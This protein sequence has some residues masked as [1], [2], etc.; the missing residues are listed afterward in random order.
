[1]RGILVCALVL[2]ASAADA[3]VFAHVRSGQPAIRGWLAEGYE[4]SATFKA[5][6]DE[7]DTLP[8]IVYIETGTVMRPGLDGALLHTVAGSRESPLLRVV[9][10]WSLTR[11]TGIATIAHE[12]QHVV[13]VLRA[14][15][16]TDSSAMTA[17]FESIGKTQPRGASQFE[18]EAAR[19]VT[20]RVLDELAQRSKR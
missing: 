16:V 19:E 12:L 6:V 2:V 1:M 8:G 9:V 4:R 10:R 11:A 18:T 7:I 3:E 13:E 5:L 14:G 20:L 17:L 15:E